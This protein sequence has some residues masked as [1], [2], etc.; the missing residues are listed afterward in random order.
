MKNGGGTPKPMEVWNAEVPF[1]GGGSKNRP[2]VVLGRNGSKYDVMMSTTHPRDPEHSMRPMDPYGAGLDSR[3]YIVTS[4]IY[5]LDASK[6]EYYI[7]DLGDDDAA[8]LGA[9]YDRMR[10]KRWTGSKRRPRYSRGPRTG[11]AST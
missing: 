11:S 1:D 10:K 4:K 5:R 6:F 2:V 9:K 8:I 7:G 3:S